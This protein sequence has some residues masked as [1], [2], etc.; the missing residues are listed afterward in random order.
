MITTKLFSLQHEIKSLYKLLKNPGQK[1]QHH[2]VKENPPYPKR[3]NIPE[4][5]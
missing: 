3:Q 5:F 1:L 4:N 2:E